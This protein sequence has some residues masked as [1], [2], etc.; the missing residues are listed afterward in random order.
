[1]QADLANLIK[2]LL[3]KNPSTRLC[4]NAVRQHPFFSDFNFQEFHCIIEGKDYVPSGAKLP[5]VKI[6]GKL[7]LNYDA[8]TYYFDQRYKNVKINKEY[9]SYIKSDS[10]SDNDRDFADEDVDIL[11]QN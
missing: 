9:Y 11:S 7:I 5:R 1:M 10:D 3:D 6:P 4:G 2:K 8:D